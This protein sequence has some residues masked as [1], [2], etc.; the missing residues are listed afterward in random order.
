MTATTKNANLNINT[1]TK[2]SKELKK[3]TNDIGRMAK[4]SDKMSRTLGRLRGLFFSVFG[5][6]GVRQLVTMADTMQLL[7]D[8]ISIFTGSAESAKTAVKDIATAADETNTSISAFATTFNRVA[9]ATQELGLDTKQLISFTKTLQNTFRLSGSTMAEAAGAS[10]QLAQ[11]LASG[12]LRG[13]E[14]RSVLEQNAVIGDVLSKALNTTRGNLIK[15]AEAGTITSEVVLNALS[16]NMNKINSDALKL[17]T[18]FAQTLTKAM[19]KLS[20]AIDDI[21]TKYSL[22]VKFGKLVDFSIRNISLVVTTLATVAIPFLIVGLSKLKISLAA[23]S[24]ANPFIAIVTTIGAATIA[25]SEYLA[26]DEKVATDTR[27]RFQ[28]LTNEIEESAQRIDK[29]KR[30]ISDDGTTQSRINNKEYNKA[31]AL[32]ERLIKGLK[33]RRV[34]FAG[35]NKDRNNTKKGDGFGV[36]RQISKTIQSVKDLNIHYRVGKV[37][38]EDYS[39]ELKKI[40]LKELN[41]SFDRGSLSIKAYQ[42]SMKDLN[43]EFDKSE[44]IRAAFLEGSGDYFDS[45]GSLTDELAGGVNKAFG[46]M[47][48]HIFDFVKTGKFAFN[49]FAE[50]VLDDL[51]RIVIRTQLM[52][53]I[54]GPL[55]GSGGDVGGIPAIDSASVTGSAKGNIF[56]SGGITPFASGGVV[57]SPTFFPMNSGTGL[58][59]EDGPEAIV[60]LKRTSTGDLG[61]QSTP[62][63]V[64]VNVNNYAGVDVSVEESE[65][66]NGKVLELTVNKMVNNAINKGKFDRTMSANFG[67]ARKGSR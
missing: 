35:L 42:K 33:R 31:I 45:I 50:S 3:I 19:N 14:L 6:L 8:R 65:N 60:P 15:F 20:L 21:N 39:E 61:I 26:A 23:L 41:E 51:L 55:F 43:E 36:D 25:L 11:G 9:L 18:T 13:Q 46:S 44:G 16:K 12:Q 1:K 30:K 24:S 10:V 48:D 40:K 29:L 4:N 52:K 67:L 27:T 22:N 47:E 49:D 53:S 63:N 59:G 64:T 66:A 58:M 37:A 56:Q 32:E 2:G 57:N 17:G 28:S 38:L 62:S 7:R 5:A 54:V 34:E